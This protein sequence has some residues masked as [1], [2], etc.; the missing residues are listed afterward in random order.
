MWDSRLENRPLGSVRTD[1]HVSGHVYLS[2]SGSWVQDGREEGATG[3]R[4]SARST[5][6]GCISR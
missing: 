6:A 4:P 3:E 2:Q 1:S 5:T